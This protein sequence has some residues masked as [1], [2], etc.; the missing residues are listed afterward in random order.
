MAE[1][2]IA[3]ADALGL[4]RF[5]LIGHSMGGGIAMKVMIKQP[6][7]IRTLTLV[8][9]MSPYGYSGSNTSGSLSSPRQR[10]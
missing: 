6:E 3:T 9:T 2:V 5:H 4:D 10:W 8:D 7:R 1:D